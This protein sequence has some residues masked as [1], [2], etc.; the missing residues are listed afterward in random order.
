MNTHGLAGPD[1]G[2]WLPHA[3][4]LRATAVRFLTEGNQRDE[5]R[6]LAQCAIEF[7]DLAPGHGVATQVDITLRCTREI[8]TQLKPDGL[9]GVDRE[10]S[11]LLTR[12]KQAII[13][14]L[15]SRYTLGS[16]DARAAAGPIAPAW[17]TDF[18]LRELET[19]DEMFENVKR[20]VKEDSFSVHLERASEGG[21]LL[22][23]IA[24][25]DEGPVY[26]CPEDLTQ[27]QV[28][29]AGQCLDFLIGAA[30][31]LRDGVE[32]SILLKWGRDLS[33]LVRRLDTLGIGVFIGSTW[34]APPRLGEE[35][36]RVQAVV[37][38]VRKGDAKI[39]HH[40]SGGEWFERA[41]MRSR[42]RF[43]EEAKTPRNGPE[44][45][46]EA[47]PYPSQPALHDSEKR[48]GNPAPQAEVG[49]PKYMIKE[50]GWRRRKGKYDRTTVSRWRIWYADEEVLLPEWLGAEFLVFLLAHQ[51]REFG[52]DTLTAAVRKHRPA[53]GN[54]DRSR[55]G[56]WD[57]EHGDGEEVNTG[58]R[59]G[60]LRARDVMWGKPE[61]AEA[62]RMIKALENELTAHEEAGDSSSQSRKTVKERLEE[63]QDLLQAN[64]KLVK[65]KWVPRE[66]QE[67]TFQQMADL[68]RKHIRKLLQGYLRTNCR[69]LFDHLHNRDVLLFGTK[70]R[71]YP[72]PRV[73]WVVK[74]KGTKMGT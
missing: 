65:G 13:A 8:L 37:E 40:W 10:D 18:D 5:A 1:Q 35:S 58:L 48:E 34:N 71:Y 50:E 22:R 6:A 36:R 31:V 67:G 2:T 63:R 56:E 60:E 55:L 57:G 70:N 27:D 51:G 46:N 59:V 33:K 62:R 72:S 44:E 20:R 11:E 7:G 24:G 45:R 52:A 4:D 21:R 19:V 14:A 15:P 53:G 3:Y 54:G 32:P 38:L 66:Y 43:R 47:P 42:P 25:T 16:F 39:Q 12:L 29:V 9:I 49:R 30:G 69:P 41:G 61:I 28:D 74:R 73:D 68:I 64:A 23:I 17:E 26:A